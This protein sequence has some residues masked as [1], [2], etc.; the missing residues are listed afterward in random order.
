MPAIPPHKTA[1]TDSSWDGPAAKANLKNDADEAYYR[2]AFA[3]QDSDGDPKTKAAYKFIHHMVASGGEVGAANETACSTGIGVLNGG[4]GGT[5]IPSSDRKGVWNHLAKHL[6]DAG[7]EPPDLTSEAE[8]E[9]ALAASNQIP[10]ALEIF[11]ND[12]PWAITPRAI[13]ISKPW[14]RAWASRWTTATAMSK[15]IT[16]LP[17]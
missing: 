9:Q 1:T 17:W 2:K 4:R 10:L 15:I 13:P 14:R 12:R 11:A 16:A 3:W 7:K 5:K 8:Y 6:R